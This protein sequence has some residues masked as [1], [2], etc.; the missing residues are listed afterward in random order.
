MQISNIHE[1]IIV[2]KSIDTRFFRNV[3]EADQKTRSKCFIGSKATRLR[4]MVL[5]PIKHSC[6]FFKHYINNS[7]LYKEEGIALWEN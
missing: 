5:N 7:A 1:S 6:S 4:L 3:F 2:M